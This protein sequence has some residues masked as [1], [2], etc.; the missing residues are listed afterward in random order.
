MLSAIGGTIVEVRDGYARGELPLVEEVMQPTRVYH[1]GAITTLADE[2]ASAAIHGMQTWTEEE[3]Y[4]KPFPYSIQL[5][6]NLL[7][8]DSEGP[9]TAEA[10][11]VRRGRLTVV[12]TVVK[13]SNGETA[14]LMRSTHMMVDLKKTGSH[15]RK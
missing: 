15:K 10:N 1:A 6:V 12:D 7:K 3:M 8:N 5:S 9:L 11:V 4:E 13:T 14:A 2:V